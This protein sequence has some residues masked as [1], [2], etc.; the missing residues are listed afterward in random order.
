[1]LK[2]KFNQMILIFDDEMLEEVMKH[3]SR[4]SNVAVVFLGTLGLFKYP[5]YV[6]PALPLASIIMGF[7]GLFITFMLLVAIAISVWKAYYSAIPNR[8]FHHL[9]IG[10]ALFVYT[11][12]LGLAGFFV[13][14]N[15]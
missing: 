10:A 2:N 15:A 7:L 5:A 12:L 4:L 8:T 1:M 3:V 14:L 13:A 6:F 9:F 11:L